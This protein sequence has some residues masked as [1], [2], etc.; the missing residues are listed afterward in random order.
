VTALR[1]RLAPRALD[2]KRSTVVLIRVLLG[3]ESVL[4]SVLAPVLPHYAHAFG[5]SKPAI[6]V[7]AAAYPAG[8]LPGSLLGGW[9]ATRTGVRRTTVVGL[10][11]FT[12]SIVA[13]GFGSDILALDG[14]RFVQG[15]ACGCI[16]GGG[17]A[18]VIAISP[19]DRRGEMLGSVLASAIFGTLL[20][21]MLGT[22]AVA[23]GTGVVFACVGGVSLAL[24]A[25]TLQHPEPPRAALGAGAPLRALAKDPRVALGCWLILLEACTIGAAGTLLPLRLSRFGAS[26]VAIGLTFVLASFVSL[27]LNP[28]VG[29]VVDRRGVRL[30]LSAGLGATAVLLLLLP[31]PQSPLWLAALTVL[32]LGGPLTG[33]GLPAI[34]IMTDAIER[35]GAALAFGSM[36]FNLAWATGETVGA[37]AAASV[38]RAT[39]DAVPLAALAALMLATLVI[40]RLGSVISPSPAPS[41]SDP[42]ADRRA[43]RRESRSRSRRGR[44][45]RAERRLEGPP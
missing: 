33:Y 39:S 9:I 11:L 31:L 13:F 41:R 32:T 20:G 10:L 6:G 8:M 34:S 21:P 45:G 4:Y 35:I 30:P 14:L 19:R 7:L 1:T 28:A 15:I 22:V 3:F 16:W 18:W 12:I 44:A 38:S 5:A 43:S 29:R 27:L 24:T 17:L 23:A 25:W 42:A 26:A 37:P 2:P 40:V 36:L